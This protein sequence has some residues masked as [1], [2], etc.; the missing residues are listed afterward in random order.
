MAAKKEKKSGNSDMSRGI[1]E[2][3]CFRKYVFAVVF[4]L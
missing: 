3:M 4:S 1:K 2:L